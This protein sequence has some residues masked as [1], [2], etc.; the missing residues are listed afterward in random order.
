MFLETNG[1]PW[2]TN[3]SPYGTHGDPYET[4]GSPYESNGHPYGTNGRPA[5]HAGARKCAPAR[6]SARRRVKV[7]AGARKCTPARASARR[8]AQ[9]RL[10]ART[11]RP[12]LR[13][14]ALPDHRMRVAF[15]TSHLDDERWCVIMFT[16][17]WSFT[18]IS[19]LRCTNYPGP[20]PTHAGGRAWAHA[21]PC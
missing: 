14:I 7:H 6:A 1:S 10:H 9:V 11:P 19:V 8:R 2:G 16:A 15:G 13:F 4:N 17:A 3:G 5:V 12:F 18:S 21:N 20:T